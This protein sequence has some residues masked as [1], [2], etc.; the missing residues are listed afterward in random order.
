MCLSTL[1]RLTEVMST[2]LDGEG[3]HEN[4]PHWKYS[5]FY[6]FFVVENRRFPIFMKFATAPL[7]DKGG[8]MF[9]LIW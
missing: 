9:T 5:I 1:F 3:G 6:R 2:L 4:W 7:C 8:V